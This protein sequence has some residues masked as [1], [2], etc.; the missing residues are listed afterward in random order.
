M[1][2]EQYS[3]HIASIPTNH[4]DMK[5]LWQEDCMLCKNGSYNNITQLHVTHT[6]LL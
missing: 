4:V 1:Q 2:S 5:I 3:L 6:S